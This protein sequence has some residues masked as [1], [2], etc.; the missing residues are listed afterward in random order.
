MNPH[1]QL[2]CTTCG[3]VTAS[4]HAKVAEFAF[5]RHDCARRIAKTAHQAARAARKAHRLPADDQR[6]GKRAGYLAGCHCEPCE[7][8]HSVYTKRYKARVEGGGSTMTDARPVAAHVDRLHEW[9]SYGAIAAAAGV[10]ASVVTGLRQRRSM[11]RV[12]AAQILAVH[13]LV[14]V[15][16]HYVAGRGAARRLQ[17]L[18]ALGYSMRALADEVGLSMTWVQKLCAHP[19]LQVEAGNARL[20]ADVYQRLAMRV[21]VGADRISRGAVEHARRAAARKGWVPPL[22]W[23][24]IDRDEAPAQAVTIASGRRIDLDEWVHLVSL[25]VGAVEAAGRVGGSNLRSVIDAAT[26]YQHQRALRLLAEVVRMS[27][28]Q[29]CLG[30]ETV[31]VNNARARRLEQLAERA[32]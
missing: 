11:S 7:R 18:N 15:G 9:M 4:Q 19:E 26:K 29:D 3:Y 10:P 16:A 31:D 6:H 32:A 17:A 2:F 30:R 13:P 22:G 1:E 14:A 21:P 27:N 8:A 20:V 23:D 5:A 12:R 24:D 28:A 25:G